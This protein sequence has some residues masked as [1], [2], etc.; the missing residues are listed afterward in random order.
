MKHTI[1][2]PLCPIYKEADIGAEYMDEA[3]F[4]QTC[5]LLEKKGGFCLIHTDYDYT[6]WVKEDCITDAE[7]TPTHV[8][9]SAIGDMLIEPQNCHRAALDLP[10]GSRV[11]VL[12]DGGTERYAA[13]EAFDGK[14]YYLHRKNLCTVDYLSRERTEAQLR[15]DIAETAKLFLGTG[16]RWGGKTAMGIDCSGLAFMSYYMN[17]LHIYRDAHV[18]RSPA[19]RLIGIKEAK[20]GDLLFFPGHVAVYLGEGLFI[21]STTALG[22]VGYNSFNE[23]SPIYSENLKNTLEAVAT[24]F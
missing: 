7:Y 10:R 15:D 16:Y 21:H 2:A 1:C 4:G 12:E 13:V 6:G 8:I 18:D 19:L 3:F 22:G 20:K 17:G 24:A 5:E 23:Y 14:T 11:K 9:T